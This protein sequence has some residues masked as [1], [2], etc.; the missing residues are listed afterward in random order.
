MMTALRG[1]WSVVEVIDPGRNH[2]DLTYNL[3]MRGTP[4]GDA[5]LA[6]LEATSASEALP[7]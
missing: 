5:V 2:F 7:R 4:L 3:G 6:Q 1:R